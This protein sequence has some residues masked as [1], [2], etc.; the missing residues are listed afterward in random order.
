MKKRYGF[1]MVALAATVTIMLILTTAITIGGVNTSNNAKKI[2]FATELKTLQEA[3]DEYVNENNGSYPI[4]NSVVVDITSLSTEN[5]QQFNK[6]TDGYNSGKVLL[7]DIDYE[8]I[9]VKSLKYGDESNGAND[10]YVVSN[11]SG[12]VY[13]AKGLKIGNNTYYTLNDE[14]TTLLN[15]NADKNLVNTASVIVFQPNTTEWTK[16]GIEV[17]V[18]VPKTFTVSKIESGGVNIPLTSSE[19]LYNN[20][21]VKKASNYQIN[22]TYTPKGGSVTT[23][24]YEVKNFDNTAPTFTIDKD[25]QIKNNST[26]SNQIGYV[27]ILNK[28]DDVSGIKVVK[29]ENDSLYTVDNIT[30]GTI[31]KDE[32]KEHFQKN[33]KVLTTDI[34]PIEKN[35]G[36][37]TVYMEDKAGNASISTFDVSSSLIEK[38]EYTTDDYIQD[39]LILHYDGINNTGLG[40]DDTSKVWVDLSGNGN[41]GVIS[42]ETFEYSGNGWKNGKGFAF[43]NDIGV[44]T[45]NILQ[46][47][48]FSNIDSFTVQVKGTFNKNT[49]TTT[50]NVF[51]RIISTCANYTAE[52]EGIDGV[53]LTYH[54]NDD[55]IRSFCSNG[56]KN[57]AYNTVFDTKQISSINIVWNK[58]TRELKYYLDNDEP[59]TVK[60]TKF[61]N[62]SLTRIGLDFY[63]IA[64]NSGVYVY[65]S[66]KVY[67]RALSEEEIKQNYT[68]DKVRFGL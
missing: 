21:V 39:G 23:A 24:T 27:K 8:K 49:A 20:Y 56:I 59:I 62:V 35:V 60:I 9:N 46:K 48:T 44:N 30:N 26:N 7:Y 54:S 33:G 34:V 18:K 38:N 65:N 63:R 41:D 6:E 17:T 55:F 15:E 3:V 19:T 29:Y 51:T 43:E 57:N 4:G 25:N 22:V 13:Y 28:K 40:H 37:I 64:D 47:T 5:K 16:D 58:N 52:Y 61:D 1:S 14:L 11:T 67:N 42:D 12:V 66:I 50:N 53:D 31:T 32:V 68:V 2:A 45:A 36:K 10:I